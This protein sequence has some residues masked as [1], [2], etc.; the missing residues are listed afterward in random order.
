MKKLSLL[1]QICFVVVMAIFLLY[2]PI[3]LA[4]ENKTEIKSKP[5]KNIIC[6]LKEMIAPGT[7]CKES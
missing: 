1:K 3:M 6:T 4:N 2:L 7:Q 5:S